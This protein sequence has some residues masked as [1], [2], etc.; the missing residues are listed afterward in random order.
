MGC[1]D[2]DD[3][4]SCF[5]LSVLFMVWIDV[6]LRPPLSYCCTSV[7]LLILSGPFHINL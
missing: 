2:C 6:A 3:L 4:V 7:S 5:S 1:D